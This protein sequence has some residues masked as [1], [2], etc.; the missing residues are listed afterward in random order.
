MTG[1][2]RIVRTHEYRGEVTAEAMGEINAQIS[3]L[4]E[5]GVNVKIET[6]QLTFFH[7]STHRYRMRVAFRPGSFVHANVFEGWLRDKGWYG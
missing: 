2:N 4:I 3:P 5:A 1:A 6:E 7:A